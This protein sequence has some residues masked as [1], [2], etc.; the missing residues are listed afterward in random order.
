VAAKI[1]NRLSPSPQA[2]Q[3]NPGE[4]PVNVLVIEFIGMAMVALCIIV[5]AHPCRGPSSRRRTD[6]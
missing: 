4:I 1:N 2:Y 3:L 6:S 5:L